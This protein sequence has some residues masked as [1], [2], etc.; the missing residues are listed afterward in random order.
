MAEN[1]L[2]SNKMIEAEIVELQKKIE[3]KRNQLE[4]QSG[5][6]EEKS[7]VREAF[8]E[9]IAKKIEEE[10]ETTPASKVDLVGEP[11]KTSWI[12]VSASYLDRLDEKTIS[13]LN[14]YIDEINQQGI[15]R[16]LKKAITDEPFVIDALHDILVDKLYEE[17]KN[18]GLIK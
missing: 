17:L 5:I 18:R 12:N 10:P 16:T 14:I 11:Q 15:V 7:L 4:K 2:V 13:K 9:M 3:E 8:Q 1:F 6:M